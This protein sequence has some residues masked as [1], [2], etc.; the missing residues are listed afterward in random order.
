MIEKMALLCWQH[1]RL[2][3][4]SEQRLAG[5]LKAGDD[6]VTALLGRE[7]TT[8]A[9]SRLDRAINRLHRDLLF[10]A[11]YRQRAQEADAKH[12]AKQG[13]KALLGES[14]QQE[15]AGEL[16]REVLTGLSEPQS[17]NAET[18]GSQGETPVRSAD[19][20]ERVGTKPSPMDSGYRAA[21]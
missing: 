15:E 19:W 9:E 17:E 12:H 11:H 4:H 13:T 2:V 8:M 14:G 6:I 5:C 10:L 20:R 16:P 7:A 1:D 18:L 3:A 21:S